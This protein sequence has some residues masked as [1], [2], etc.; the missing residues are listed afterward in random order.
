VSFVSVLTKKNINEMNELMNKSINEQ[1]NEWLA[2]AVVQLTWQSTVHGRV[3]V[4]WLTTKF[5]TLYEI[6]M[7]LTI[8]TKVHLLILSYFKDTFSYYH[9]I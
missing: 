3:L 7:S 9:S 5:P 2:T 8:F 1:R 4:S 6:W